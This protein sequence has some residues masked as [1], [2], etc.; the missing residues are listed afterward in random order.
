[1]K[2]VVWIRYIFTSIT[3]LATTLL[4]CGCC[5]LLPRPI[6]AQIL[7]NEF[8]HY[9]LDDWVEIINISSETVDLTEYAL[10]DESTNKEDLIGLLEPN[11][12][13]SFEFGKWLNKD[14]DTVILIKVNESSEEIID[15][16]PYGKADSVCAASPDGAI[17]RYPDGGN[18]LERFKIATRDLPN[19]E[20]LDPCPTPTPEPTNSPTSTP[21]PTATLT[22]T[23][24]FKPTATNTT[25]PTLKKATPTESED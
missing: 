16:I 23:P 13:K 1:M 15:Q 8:S 25:T 5:L 3:K 9:T 2:R 10:R 4:V 24:T 12:L 18:T 21:K 11:A 14:I 17:G 22:S 20:E 19:S 6:R 7:I